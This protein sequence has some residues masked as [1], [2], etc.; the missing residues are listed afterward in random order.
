MHD[1]DELDIVEKHPVDAAKFSLKNCTRPCCGCRRR[2]ENGEFKEI[3][4]IYKNFK[5][6]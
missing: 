4:V 5:I 2:K 6:C 1:V 3:C